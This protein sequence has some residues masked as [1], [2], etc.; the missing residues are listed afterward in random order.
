MKF[1]ERVQTTRNSAMTA[2][3]C[4]ALTMCAASVATQTFPHAVSCAGI[5]TSQ[6]Y[7]TSWGGEMTITGHKHQHD[8]KPGWTYLTGQQQSKE[9]VEAKNAAAEAW[10]EYEQACDVE[11]PH[12]HTLLDKAVKLQKEAERLSR[13]W[14][15]NY[16]D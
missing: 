14:N 13:E 3:N 10:L 7:Q 1:A 6:V 8:Y 11:S 4:S 9:V 2:P 5:A 15:R 16:K 12:L